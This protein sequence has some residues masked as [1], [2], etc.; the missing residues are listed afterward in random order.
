MVRSRACDT[1]GTTTA[2]LG[3]QDATL[4][5][6]NR[7][8]CI[9]PV[10]HQPCWLDVVRER[11]LVGGTGHTHN[12]HHRCAVWESIHCT[13]HDTAVLVGARLHHLQVRA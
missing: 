9:S 11:V 4:E 3:L 10:E 5:N 2:Y 8:A 6:A 1:H 13:V 7:I 12:L